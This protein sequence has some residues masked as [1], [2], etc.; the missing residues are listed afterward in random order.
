M[1]EELS[2]F[3]I[4]HPWEPNSDPHEN[5]WNL[6][7]VIF[8]CIPVH[9]YENSPKQLSSNVSMLDTLNPHLQV[10]KPEYILAV[11]FSFF[12]YSQSTSNWY[13]FTSSPRTSANFLAILTS[14]SQTFPLASIM[15]S[16][17][18]PRNITLTLSAS[19]GK[20]SWEFSSRMVEIKSLNPWFLSLYVHI[21]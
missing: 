18:F 20:L 13:E 10:C 2:L 19:S 1:V 16:L 7:I 17:Y 3:L 6:Y 8:I 11:W 9:I 5:V 4:V 15:C 12:D 14:G 21:K